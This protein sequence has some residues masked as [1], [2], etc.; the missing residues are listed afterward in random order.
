MWSACRSSGTLFTLRTSNCPIV[1]YSAVASVQEEKGWPF[2]STSGSLPTSRPLLKDAIR[3]T[4]NRSDFAYR[5]GFSLLLTS[6]FD[7][8]RARPIGMT[9]ASLLLI[10]W[11][12]KGHKYF[13]F[14]VTSTKTY[15]R[16]E[17]G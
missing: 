7:Q 1:P 9:L 3:G 15:P 13:L 11:N 6:T 12:I 8:G 16:H 17:A 5:R 14:V 10:I 2:Y 4:G